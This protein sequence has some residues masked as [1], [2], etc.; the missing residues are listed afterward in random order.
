MSCTTLDE[1]PHAIAARE[2][3]DDR[4]NSPTPPLGAIAATSAAAHTRWDQAPR[5]AGGGQDARRP[6][7]TGQ[8]RVHFRVHLPRADSREKKQSARYSEHMVL[9]AKNRGKEG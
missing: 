3:R 6:H 7:L 5:R 1:V 4:T 8:H 9:G 2:S